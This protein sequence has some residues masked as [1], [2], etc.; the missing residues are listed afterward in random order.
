LNDGV[1]KENDALNILGLRS[2]SNTVNSLKQID[3]ERIW[4]AEIATLSI[5]R[6]AEKTKGHKKEDQDSPDDPE[7]GAGKH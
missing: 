3:M 2:G 1:V 7:Y 4:K 6:E 5:S